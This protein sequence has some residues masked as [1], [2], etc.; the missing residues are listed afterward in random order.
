MKELS[1]IKLALEKANN[2]A[3]E[4]DTTKDHI[5]WYGDIRNII[6]SPNAKYI[7]KRKDFTNLI[8]NDDK[9]DFVASLD[10]ILNSDDEEYRRNFRLFVDN[11]KIINIEDRGT[12]VTENGNKILVGILSKISSHVKN[13][14]EIESFEDPVSV[15]NKNEYFNCDFTNKLTEIFNLNVQQHKDSAL[16]KISIDNLPVIMT[17][18]S[19]DFAE[20]VMNALELTISSLIKKEDVLNRIAI[21]QFGLIVKDYSPEEFE[22]LVNRISKYIQL[23]KN[24]SFAD[25]IHIRPSMGS[26]IFPSNVSNVDDACN[27]AFLALSKSKI[28]TK[29]F[30]VDFSDNS[31][32]YAKSQKQFSDLRILQESFKKGNVKL[33]FQPIVECKSGNVDSYECLLRIPDKNRSGYKSAGNLIPIAEKMGIIDLV[34]QYVLE[35]VVDELKHN[36]DISLGFNVSNIT[37]NNEKWLKLCSKLLTSEDISS[38]IT[39]EITE[40]A[41]QGD[42]RA[43]AYF[44]ASLQGLGCKV[45]LDDFGAGYTSFRQLK[46]LS[47]DTVKID[48]SYVRQLIKNYENLLFIRTLVAFNQSYGLK[49]VAE[50]VE[51]G[52]TAK[53]LMDMGVDYLQGYYFGKPDIEK[54]WLESSFTTKKVANFC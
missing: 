7:Y 32:D 29:E 34:D 39:V 1:R 19:I 38:R 40:T 18:Y 25:S 17:W 5:T 13:N 35:R 53:M 8:C 52:Q 54:P 14:N 16:V 2:V 28:S 44:I 23:Y 11:D 47:I 31:A 4:W 10:K 45:A 15:F 41:V 24:P 21:D 51:D 3:Y 30:H 9:V 26:V 6:D 43:A 22:I 46:S 12:V 50:C 48:G 42:I 33:A 49:T 20:R 37:T 36:K 27:K